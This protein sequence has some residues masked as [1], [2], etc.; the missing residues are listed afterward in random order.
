MFFL[1]VEPIYLYFVISGCRF[2]PQYN[3][4]SGWTTSIL[5]DCVLVPPQAGRS[6]KRQLVLFPGGIERHVKIKTCSVG[7]QLL[8]TIYKQPGAHRRACL[9]LLCFFQVA[10]E[11]IEELCYEMGLHRLEA[12]EE[13]A[14]FLVTNRGLLPDVCSPLSV[15]R[16]HIKRCNSAQT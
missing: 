4:S 10:L 11:V 16:T 2:Q 7:V 13:Y 3:M 12:M 5:N 6:S 9:M 8:F 14:I 1:K 15:T